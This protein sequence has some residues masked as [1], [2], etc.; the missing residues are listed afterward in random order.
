MDATGT[1]IPVAQLATIEVS[2][3]VTRYAS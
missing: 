1:A 3:E 2:I